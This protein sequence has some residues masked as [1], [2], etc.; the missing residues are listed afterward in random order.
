MTVQEI[1]N[2]LVELCRK[3]E[4]DTCYQELYSPEARSIEPE[5]TPD[6]E[7]K[8]MDAFKAKGEKWQSMIQEVHSSEIGDPVVAGNHFSLTWKTNLTFKGAPAPTDMDEICVYQV[9]DGK[10]V[11]EQFFYEP[12]QG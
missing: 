12:P 11:K 2:R 5:G 7:V 9:K 1:A 6:R 3:G 8:G 4:W 10:I